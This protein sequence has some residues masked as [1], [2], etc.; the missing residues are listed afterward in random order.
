MERAFYYTIRSPYY[1][2]DVSKEEWKR[3]DNSIYPYAN[4]PCWVSTWGRIYNENMRKM[5][6]YRTH[7]KDGY[8]TIPVKFIYPSG[9]VKYSS[10]LL[11]RSILLAFAPREDAASLD[12]N[13]N[14]GDKDNNHI[15][16]LSWATRSENIKFAYMN[17]LRDD[18]PKGLTHYKSV[19]TEEE[20]DYIC[21]SL[22]EGKSCNDIADHIGCTAQVVSHILNGTT[23][24]DKYNEYELYKIRKHRNTTRLTKDQQK[25]AKEYMNKNR[26][27]FNS[28]RE[29][30]IAALNHVGYP[31]P[32]VSNKALL[33]YMKRLDLR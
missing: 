26:N 16:N 30:Y 20:L 21:K 11:S 32:D 31:D 33:I 3:V 22:L 25:E 13:H 7:N 6:E 1:R 28:K 17:G 19:L 9:E 24:K 14:D 8:C 29:M 10:M 18:Q 15:L 5:I 23:Y 4:G 12:A 27:N 2:R